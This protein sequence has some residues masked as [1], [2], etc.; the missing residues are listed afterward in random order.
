VVRKRLAIEKRGVRIREE[1]RYFFFITNDREM[2]AD[3]VV[4]TAGSRCDQENL[5]AQLKGGVHAL[6]TPVDNLVSNW[7]YMV[8]ASL[9]W[10]L[11]AWAA[12]LV[13]E[14][15]RHA[16]E[17]RAQKRTLL[18]MEFATFRAAMIE[19]PCQVVRGGR[20]LVYRLLSWNPWQGAFLRL[21]ERLNGSWLY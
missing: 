16:P 19:I 7:A 5:V 14:T 13:P 15:P 20:R 1:Y 12:L 9:A 6:T 8:M 18:R 3:Q 17:H 11:K 2:A 21:V 4:L 10:S